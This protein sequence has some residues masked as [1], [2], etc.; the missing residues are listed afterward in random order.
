MVAVRL[1][2][3]VLGRQM[4]L[5]HFLVKMYF[6]S[7]WE[8][9]LPAAVAAPD[10]KIRQCIQRSALFPGRADGGTEGPELFAGDAKR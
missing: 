9:L 8:L 2:I 7:S 3:R 6:G 10:H 5:V 4:N 1:L